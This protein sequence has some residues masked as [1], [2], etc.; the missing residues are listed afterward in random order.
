MK[1][2]IVIPNWQGRELLKKNLPRVLEIGADEVIVVENGSTDGSA[3]YIKNQISKLKSTNQKLKIIENKE[4]LGFAKG[5]NQGVNEAVGDVVIL[6]NTDVVPEKDLLKHVL[7]HFE[8][9]DVFAVSFNEGEWSWAK[10]YVKYG[11]IEH[12]SGEKTKDTHISFWASG[13]S[14][15]FDRKRWL[16][17]GGF[18]LIYEPFY[19]EDTDISYRAQKHG[20]EV[21][22]EPKAVVEHKHEATVKKHSQASRKD[23]IA[24]RNQL[25]FFWCNISSLSLWVQHILWMPIKLLR[26]GYW[27][28]FVWAIL[29]LPDVLVTRLNNS[30]GVSDEEI[31]EKFKN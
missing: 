7:P 24:Q 14:A 6:L 28:P 25:L 21:L 13:G 9:P 19:W 11:L 23:L 29:K 17:L 30:G 22:W 2:S 26:P 4:N 15:A 12:S 3:E 8:K 10:G 5:V 27:K 16:E 1:T 20:W 18:N 31:L